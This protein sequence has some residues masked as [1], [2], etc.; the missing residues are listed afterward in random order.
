M[1]RTEPHTNRKTQEPKMQTMKTYEK[2]SNNDAACDL[3]LEMF[4]A[5]GGMAQRIFS[6]DEMETVRFLVKAKCVR[7]NPVFGQ[8][9]LSA[10]GQGVAAELE[11]A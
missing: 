1:A 6:A 7:L 3:L 2:V 4:D 8:Y 11:Y 10:L 5:P 9:E